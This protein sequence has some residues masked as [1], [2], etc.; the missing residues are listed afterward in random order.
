VY[1]YMRRIW[2]LF[3]AIPLAL[4]LDIVGVGEAK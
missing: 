2:I 1:V 4:V 3:N